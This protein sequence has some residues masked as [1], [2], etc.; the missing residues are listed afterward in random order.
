MCDSFNFPRTPV[1]SFTYRTEHVG[2]WKVHRVIV[3]IMLMVPELFQ[4]YNGA[5]IQFISLL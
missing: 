2:T 4:R 1:R 3:Y 5:K